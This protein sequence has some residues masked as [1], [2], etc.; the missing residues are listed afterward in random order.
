MGFNFSKLDNLSD[1]KMLKVFM[2]FDKDGS[3][4]VDTEELLMM[5]D[6]LKLGTD[7]PVANAEFLT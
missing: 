7:D 3:L 1:N 2:E 4:T 5:M 6:E